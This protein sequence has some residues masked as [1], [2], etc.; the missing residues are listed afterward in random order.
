MS[1]SLMKPNFS[2]SFSGLIGTAR[3]ILG[4]NTSKVGTKPAIAAA[5]TPDFKS[6][7]RLMPR[8]S[9]PL[10]VVTMEGFVLFIRVTRSSRVRLE[11]IK[12]PQP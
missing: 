5:L 6:D 9:V 4:A 3:A 10:I 1:V 2:S 8:P 7:R 11:P 12:K